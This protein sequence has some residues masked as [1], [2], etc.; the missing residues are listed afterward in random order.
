[1]GPLTRRDWIRGV[2]SG[3]AAGAIGSAFA[4]AARAGERGLFPAYESFR[5]GMIVIPAGNFLMGTPLWEI[6]ALAIAHGYHQSWMDGELP[7]HTV[8]LPAY[9]ID[10]Y[11]VTQRDFWEFCNATGYPPRA[12]W[13]A[14][15]PPVELLEHPVTHV[16]HADAVAYANWIGKRLPTEA[17]WEK[18]ARGAQGQRF[19]WGDLFEADKC[20]WNSD[21]TSPGPGTARVDAHRLGASP[22]GVQDMSGNVGEW[23]ADGPAPWTSYIKGGAWITTQV[24]N[25]RPAARNMSGLS[26]NPS[27]YVGFRCARDLS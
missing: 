1:M 7:E 12:N 18:A 13:V 11:P 25:L 4:G 27:K 2:G 6:Q 24:V 3:V 9:A 19:P 14:G 17:E 22:F 23:C 10:K 8:F 15:A 5:P 20:R 26:G 21:P 16:S